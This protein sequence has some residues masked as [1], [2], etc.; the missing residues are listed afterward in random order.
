MGTGFSYVANNAY[1]ETLPQVGAEFLHF[2]TEFVQAYPEYDRQ[3]HAEHGPGGAVDVY[4]A[5]ESYAGQFLPY[6]ADAIVR[7][8]GGAPVHLAGVAIGNGYLDPKRQAGSEVDVLVEAGVWQADGP[9][10][11][12]MAKTVRACQEA[13]ARDATP[14]VEYAACDAI[15][16]DVLAITTRTVNGT[17]YCLNSYDLRLVDTSPA[18]GMNWPKELAATYAYL[19]QPAVRAALH[20]DAAHH[21]EAWIECNAA[22]GRPIHAHANATDASVTL[23][24]RLLE[25]HVPVLVFAGEQDVICNYVGLQR[26]VD[27]LEWGGKRGLTTPPRDWRIDGE[28]VGRWQSDR[29]LTFVRVHNA[30]HMVAYDQPLAAHDMMLRFMDVDMNL[31]GGV[32]ARNTSTVGLDTRVLV[33]ERGALH[34]PAHA[35]SAAAR[36]AASAAASASARP[37]PAAAQAQAAAAHS[38]LLGNV[39]VVA[40][41][42]LAVGGCLWVRRR[43][44]ARAPSYHAV[45]QYVL[46]GDAPG[47]RVPLRSPPPAERDVEMEPFTLGEADGERT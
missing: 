12:R 38:D 44:R 36:P 7:A 20:V 9:E 6:I 31:G 43:T 35:P 40:L 26:M 13:L 25:A 39:F 2:L 22:V 18:C 47:G 27:A 3:R 21:P 29:N 42:A 8:P 15:L 37:A 14:R 5:G 16:S 1:A 28:L 24:P 4:L 30:S 11:K 17:A 10:V 23:L 45:G 46:G 34:L 33:P 32:A 41:I 19:R